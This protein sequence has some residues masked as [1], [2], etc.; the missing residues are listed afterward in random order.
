MNLSLLAGNAALKGQLEAQT[1]RRGLSHAYILS[2]PAG[3][4]KCTLSRVLAAA[5]VCRGGGDKPCLS[6]PDCRKA[7][8]GIHPDISVI[9]DDGKDIN[10]AQIR[11]L[12][13]DAYI[14]PNEAGRKVYILE[15][16]Q[17]MNASAQN[18][19]LKLLEE[20]P[21]YAAFLLLTDNAATLLQ[22]V[23][24]RCETLALSPVTEA[25]A[26]DWLA[27]RYPDRARE[28]IVRAA[29]RCEGLLGRA[30]AELEGAGDTGV[31]ARSAAP[32]LIARLSAG[33]ELAWMEFCISLE[34]WDRDSLSA[35]F[36][37]GILLL[38]H[39]LVLRAGG[40]CGEADPDRRSA[41]AQAARAL[42]PRAMLAATDVLERLR[43]AC[44]FNVGAGHLAGWLCAGLVRCRG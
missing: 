4:G 34:K 44:T 35:L 11:S 3:V 40:D 41:A 36:S 13:A 9:G 6:C 17:T 19:M 12:R 39:A 14:R 5:F 21:P 25:E 29:R 32:E 38:R 33:D 37:E 43:A 28:D 26:E 30:V 18:A 7:L 27:R 16:A 8:G 31:Q 42:S 20:G 15:N 2:G 10:V 23:R 1:A 22:T 24:S